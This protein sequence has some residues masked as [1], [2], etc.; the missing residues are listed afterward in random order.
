MRTNRL[1]LIFLGVLAALVRTTS[2]AHAEGLAPAVFSDSMSMPR[3][4]REI[5]V[6]IRTSLL[7]L[8]PDTNVIAVLEP[9]FSEDSVTVSIRVLDSKTGLERFQVPFHVL[10]EPT[11]NPALHQLKSGERTKVLFSKDS[12]QLFVGRLD[13]F[14]DVYD[15]QSGIRTNRFVVPGN[16]RIYFMDIA[17]GAKG[18]VLAV[19]TVLG[20][21]L[22]D[23]RTGALLVGFPFVLPA[24][25]FFYGRVALNGNATLLADHSPDGSVR[26]FDVQKRK[27]IIRKG[28]H[29][30]DPMVFAGQL[31]ISTS[32][33]IDVS[34]LS[35][36]SEDRLRIVNAEIF[37]TSRSSNLV[38]DLATATLTQF[39]QRKIGPLV[40]QVAVSQSA[41]AA[42]GVLVS[43][44]QHAAHPLGCVQTMIEMATYRQFPFP[45]V[46]P[47]ITLA[48]RSHI[49]FSENVSVAITPDGSHSGVIHSWNSGLREGA[50]FQLFALVP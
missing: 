19:A 11:G 39:P 26:V 45:Q 29:F 18:Q 38:L 40:T 10:S 47:K 13:G 27:E 46:V 6:P 3:L 5:D 30:F 23:G 41:D 49:G 24:A 32:N 16:P 48:E 14:V 50:T 37:S 42:V 4:V 2:V 20:T 33:D 43:S 25:E 17:Q 36:L 9:E 34:A 28:N 1:N 22:L 15:V 8:S 35:F 31:G 12:R 21:C 44:R 7:A